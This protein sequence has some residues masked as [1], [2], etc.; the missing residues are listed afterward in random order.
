MNHDINVVKK[1]FEQH[2]KAI[3]PAELF[4]PDIGQYLKANWNE[5][6]EMARSTASIAIKN[7]LTLPERNKVR[8][9]NDWHRFRGYLS[10]VPELQ[11]IASDQSDILHKVLADTDLNL[12]ESRTDDFRA[13]FEFQ[14]MLVKHINHFESQKTF[15][16]SKMTDQF[17]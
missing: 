10:R 9:R 13:V 15:H 5:M 3:S 7:Y 4:I 8:F 12:S 2:F 1:K 16:V 11:R 17:R 14:D 6:T